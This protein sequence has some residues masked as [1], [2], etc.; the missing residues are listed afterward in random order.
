[1]RY[2]PY[3]GGRRFNGGVGCWS[4]SDLTSP[5]LGRIKFTKQIIINRAGAGGSRAWVSLGS[6]ERETRHLW[7]L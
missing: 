1:M 7:Q 5:Q 6:Y 4:N 2:I 3:G